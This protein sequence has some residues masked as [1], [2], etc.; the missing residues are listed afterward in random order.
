MGEKIS[1]YGRGWTFY[2]TDGADDEHLPSNGDIEPWMQGYCAAMADYD[3][4]TWRGHASIEAAL[5]YHGISDDLLEE[6]LDAAERIL[7][8]P[9]QG[10]WPSVPVRSRGHAA[11]FVGEAANDEVG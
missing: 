4:E 7:A 2:K 8:A 5:L 3:L 10:R 11:E 6:C 9:L 1:D